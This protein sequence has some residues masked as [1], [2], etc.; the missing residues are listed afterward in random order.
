MVRNEADIVET[1][2]RHMAREVD[3]LIVADNNSTDGTRAILD[4][5]TTELPLT[6]VDDPDPAYRQSEKMTRLA[7]LAHSR[8][9]VWV[10]PFDADEI[11]HPPDHGQDLR[12]ADQLSALP[13]STTVAAADLY[14]HLRTSLDRDHT[15]PIQSM[16]WRQPEP[17]PL[18]KVAFRW[19]DG[20]VVEQGNHGVRFPDGSNDSVGGLLRVRHFPVRS[21]DH[22]IRKARQGADAY[23][24][25]PDLPADYGAHWR[26]WGQILD[27][28]GE[29]ALRAVYAEHWLYRSPVDSGLVWDPAPLRRL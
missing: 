4:H 24:A 27:S 1:V 7:D 18:A 5:L 3:Y 6:V 16:G 8:G 17:A 12:I 19:R 29:D 23:K 20:A 22:L 28:G 9:A 21:A 15:C 11:W 26:S 13:P 2:V 10:V 25:A 14:N